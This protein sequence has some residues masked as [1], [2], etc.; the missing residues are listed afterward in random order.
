MYSRAAVDSSKHIDTRSNIKDLKGKRDSNGGKAKPP[1]MVPQI[2]GT[3]RKNAAGGYHESSPS[4]VKSSLHLE[5]PPRKRGMRSSLRKQA[6]NKDSAIDVPKLLS[7]VKEWGTLNSKR[8]NS[9]HVKVSDGCATGSVPPHS[10]PEQDRSVKASI[11]CSAGKMSFAIQEN[12]PKCGA[13]EKQLEQDVT[14]HSLPVTPSTGMHQF[15]TIKTTL[16]TGKG[17]RNISRDL[18]EGK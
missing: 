14:K 8:W 15:N 6:E 9:Q 16:P 1:K 17:I 5:S 18:A 13:E 3:K 10:T 12:E 11:T 7:L 2:G 4:T